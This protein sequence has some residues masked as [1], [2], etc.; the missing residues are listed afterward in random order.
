MKNK[1]KRAAITAAQA[2]IDANLSPF[3]RE[4]SVRIAAHLQ[5]VEGY[6]RDYRNELMTAVQ[7]TP[8]DEALPLL[9]GDEWDKLSRSQKRQWVALVQGE[10]T[11]TI[12]FVQ[13]FQRAITT[14]AT[15][16]EQADSLRVEAETTRLAALEPANQPQTVTER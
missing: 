9:L 1:T 7:N 16:I 13:N 3:G 2:L 15:M 8:V 11:A 14:Q 10:M 5:Y 4:M 6:F 12:T